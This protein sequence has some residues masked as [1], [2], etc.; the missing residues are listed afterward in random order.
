[1]PEEIE[2]LFDLLEEVQVKTYGGLLYPNH[3]DT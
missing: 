2:G 3:T 1:M